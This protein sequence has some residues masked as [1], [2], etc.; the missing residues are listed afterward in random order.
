MSFRNLYLESWEY[1]IQEILKTLDT[2]RHSINIG[3]GIELIHKG[4]TWN[5]YIYQ[6]WS[7]K[8]GTED[9]YLIL[10][11]KLPRQWPTLFC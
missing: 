11:S 4:K 3:D 7:Y 5:K 6:Y 2:V 1:S 10:L 8:D 9:L